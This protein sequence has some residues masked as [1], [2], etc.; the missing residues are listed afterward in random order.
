M[1]SRQNLTHIYVW[2]MST[3]RSIGLSALHS[4]RFLAKAVPLAQVYSE[5]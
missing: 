5:K 4:D 3:C 1:I 2:S